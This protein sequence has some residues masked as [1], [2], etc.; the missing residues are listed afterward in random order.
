[1]K[2]FTRRKYSKLRRVSVSNS[3]SISAH[4][5]HW[6]GLPGSSREDGCRQSFSLS[7][8]PAIRRS[9]RPQ[10]STAHPSGCDSFKRFAISA[11]VEFISNL[12]LGMTGDI[13]QA[14]EQFADQNGGPDTTSASEQGAEF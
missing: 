3:V 1:L 5:G 12:L 11:S 2:Y 14:C 8:T 6:F 7:I 10:C 4:A 9:W 13:E